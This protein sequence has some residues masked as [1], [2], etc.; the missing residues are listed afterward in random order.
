M[1]R[2]TQLTRKGTEHVKIVEQRD[3]TDGNYYEPSRNN[4]ICGTTHAERT[5]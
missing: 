5:N 1:E 4:C 2:G 3:G